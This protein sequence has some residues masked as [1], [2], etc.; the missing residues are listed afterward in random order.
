MATQTPSEA[1]SSTTS[2]IFSPYAAQLQSS[3]AALRK[4]VEQ[5]EADERNYVALQDTLET[6]NRALTRET[7]VRIGPRALVKAQVVH[8][9]EIYTAVGDGYIIEHS[10]Y[11]ASQMAG[12]RVECM[13]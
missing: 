9:N 3:I 7:I 1:E 4:G 12:R 2:G 6:C 8:T 10:A 13:D 11:H 5:I